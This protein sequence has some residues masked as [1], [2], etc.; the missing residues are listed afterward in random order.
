MHVGCSASDVNNVIHRGE[1]IRWMMWGRRRTNLRLSYQFVK[2]II[3][4]K[5]GLCRLPRVHRRWFLTQ[6]RMDRLQ[7]ISAAELKGRY[8]FKIISVVCCS[9]DP[10]IHCETT[11]TI[12]EQLPG[13]GLTAPSTDQYIKVDGLCRNWIENK[14]NRLFLWAIYLPSIIGKQHHIKLFSNLTKLK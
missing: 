3:I 4:S 7:L 2:S 12:T 10:V 8:F 1:S 6:I 13:D 14:C 11:R 5:F 9:A